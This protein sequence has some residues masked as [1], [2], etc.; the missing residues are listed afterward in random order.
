MSDSESSQKEQGKD[1][2]DEEFD[3]D[4]SN[5]KLTKGLNS[6]ELRTIYNLGLN[7]KYA[8]KKFIVKADLESIC[9]SI[10]NQLKEGELSLREY[11]ALIVGLSR[12]E[13]KK[14]RY[15]SD[16]LTE[17]LK[18]K[19]LKKEKGKGK[20]KA[21]TKSEGDFSDIMK[22][23]AQK[24][25]E[26]KNGISFSMLSLDQNN[27]AYFGHTTISQTEV[28]NNALSGR[29]E[30][31]SKSQDDLDL[32]GQISKSFQKDAF[33]S[34][35]SNINWTANK[36][37]ENKQ[38][39]EINYELPDKKLSDYARPAIKKRHS[40][41]DENPFGKPLVKGG[42][43]F[44]FSKKDSQP[45]LLETFFQ[46]KKKKEEKEDD[47]PIDNP[48]DISSDP[49]PMSSDAGN[50]T[51]QKFTTPKKESL[52]YKE[53]VT[54]TKDMDK[55]LIP[56]KAPQEI[57]RNQKFTYSDPNKKIKYTKG[58][59]K[60]LGGNSLEDIRNT[61]KDNDGLSAFKKEE[62]EEDYQHN[63]IFDKIQN[64]YENNYGKDQRMEEFLQNA[65][66]SKINFYSS[67]YDTFFSLPQDTFN[68]TLNLSY[69]PEDLGGLDIFKAIEEAKRKNRKE[70]KEGEKE[71]D[72]N[73]NGKDDNIPPMPMDDDI[74]PMDDD[75]PPMDDTL[76]ND[77]KP[78]EEEKTD[79]RI[80]LE[81]LNEKI[82][83]G[84][85]GNSVNLK[86]VSKKMEKNNREKQSQLFYDMLAL[87]QKGNIEMEQEE[88]NDRADGIKIE[89]R[90]LEYKEPVVGVGN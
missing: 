50:K 75:I 27:D 18:T 19:G 2:L 35:S 34:S 62:L 11:G 25:P 12:V 3:G 29:K 82:F 15:I 64:I 89:L 56:K 7:E 48:P 16:K 38:G 47:F 67:R 14:L 71:G 44:D 39:D 33:N 51:E 52:D 87:A 31:F 65:P 77:L 68:A 4:G 8:K 28:F 85:E 20:K 74:P 81:N 55:K 37:D 63:E 59:Q 45:D 70:E 69:S 60:Y 73:N 6:E 46:N 57:N 66:E 41:L 32:A 36:G 30:G 22:D 42:N 58:T 1:I 72:E 53:L 90:D 49:F 83:S 10:F 40:E 79:L 86:T 84:E 9:D 43:Y 76:K 5:Q 26:T 54:K 80:L 23:Y 17:L 13:N 24:H 78:E 21:P 88:G 61:Y